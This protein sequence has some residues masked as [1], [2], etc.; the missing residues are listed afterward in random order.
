MWNVRRVLWLVCLVVVL[1]VGLLVLS[2]CAPAQDAEAQQADTILY[3]GVFY[4]VDAEFSV[5]EAVAIK[6]KTVL[7]VGSNRE[8]LALAGPETL[9]IDLQGKAV[10]PGLVDA[11]THMMGYAL[12]L[13]QVDLMGCGSAEE[14]AAKVAAKAKD[15]QPGEWILGQ[16]W[17]SNEW[18]DRS[19]PTCAPLDKAAPANP[20]VLVKQDGHSCWINSAAMRA[21]GID[22][23]TPEPD[24]GKIIRDGAGNP[25]GVLVDTAMG[26]IESHVPPVSPERQ[27]ILL[28]RA[29]RDWLAVGL[30][31]IHDMG[32]GLEEIAAVKALID[33]GDF[34]FRVY[35]NFA[36]N[37]ADL[38][39]ILKAGPAE[40]G[41]GRLVLRSVKAY[42]DGSL[43][44]RSA[45]L[46]EGYVGRP[47]DTGLLVNSKDYI[48]DLTER[49]LRAGFQVSTH[50]CGDR[51]AR[52]VLDAYEAALKSIPT[53]DHR[54]RVEH[55]QLL[56]PGDFQR[57]A[58]L[59]VIPSMQPSHC[60][61]DFPW[62]IDLLGEERAKGAY[63]W[64][65]F[66]DAGSII[67]CGSDFP[68]ERIN[69]M[70]GFYAAITRQHEDGTPA[71]GYY[72]EQR[73]IREEALKGFTIW[74]AHAAFAEKEQGSLEPGKRAD[75][76]VLDR[77]IMKAPP[78]DIIDTKV[79]LT[80]LDGK[81]V[82]R[83]GAE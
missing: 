10:V 78:R 29:V 65:S 19:F 79:V 22:A 74:A 70:L 73:M 63:A 31:G 81:I 18:A 57:F 9:R 58:S 12:G 11:H 33:Q 53:A 17:D 83:R 39:E 32:G 41:D 62:G 21:A 67:P 55:A 60:T 43:G 28:A 6:N 47:D 80:L 42:I 30:V 48:Q 26:L 8:I 76:V 15:S 1:M 51:G 66:L 77:D 64:R 72:P 5:A 24:G 2:A 59:G 36:D 7:A 38:D 46:L 68:V 45:A 14:A 44:S 3:N 34:P 52:L 71:E 20:V 56:A 54:L 37:L 75:L 35:F 16:G 82:Y 4:T 25:S 40:Y 49:C 61:S 50:A 69:P 23:G 27:R 13:D